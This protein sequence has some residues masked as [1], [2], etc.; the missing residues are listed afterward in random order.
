MPEDI[1]EWHPYLA[2]NI[3]RKWGYCLF[4]EPPRNGNRG[5]VHMFPEFDRWPK[6]NLDWSRCNT[7]PPIRVIRK[8]IH[9]MILDPKWAKRDGG[10]NAERAGK[11]YI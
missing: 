3:P 4:F 5:R 9:R 11:T 10:K 8:Y 2:R 7:C 6:G 1:G